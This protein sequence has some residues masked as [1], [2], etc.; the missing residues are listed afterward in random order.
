MKYVVTW[1]ERPTG[2]ASE[3]EAARKRILD[4]QLVMDVAA[5]AADVEEIAD[6]LRVVP[7]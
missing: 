2:S 6:R 4:L 7:R 5:G 3:Y 1:R